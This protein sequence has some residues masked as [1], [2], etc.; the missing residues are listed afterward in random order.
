MK[1]QAAYNITWVWHI[2]ASDFPST[3]WNALENYFP[4]NDIVDWIG[5][6]AYAAQSSLDDF[7]YEFPGT[8]DFVMP[9]LSKI[10]PYKP[11][12]V[13]EF[14]APAGNPRGTAQAWA[15]QAL[16]E[17]IAGR[18]PNLIGFSWW[19][20]AWSTLTPPNTTPIQVEMRVQR[21]PQLASVFRQRLNNPAVLTQP[22]FR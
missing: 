8:L 15:D 22:I 2:N 1:N 21:I 16:R 9:R 18:W 12:I 3:G 20:E 14:G 19:N 6:S 7:W 17:M 13:A 11:V 4:G 10:A 5:V